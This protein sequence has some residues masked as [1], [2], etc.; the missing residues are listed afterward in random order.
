MDD[1]DCFSFQ[2]GEKC[3]HSLPVCGK[4]ESYM[5]E[6]VKNEKEHLTQCNNNHFESSHP[7]SG[8][9]D[10]KPFENALPASLPAL[11]STTVGRAHENWLSPI[12]KD[13]E[14]CKSPSIRGDESFQHYE[15]SRMETQCGYLSSMKKEI[16]PEDQIQL[17]D[18]AISSS[19]C[20]R[21]QQQD[22]LPSSIGTD[23]T[24]QGQ[25]VPS[26]SLTE[27]LSSHQYYPKPKDSA[28]LNLIS[29]PTLKES[30]GLS[31]HPTAI[32]HTRMGHHEE[33][34]YAIHHQSSASSTMQ[35]Q[36]QSNSK[37][38]GSSIT[39]VEVEEGEV[40]KRKTSCDEK[41]EEGHRS[42]MKRQKIAP[43]I[44]QGS[45][46]TTCHQALGLMKRIRAK[47]CQTSASLN[48]TLAISIIPNPKILQG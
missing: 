39:P 41:L 43:T 20:L 34:L 16:N 35:G 15:K 48:D 18:T 33:S 2:R 26:F 4:D 3:S 13:E 45:N 38:S 8:K 27:R 1:A 5:Y 24:D 25:V 32:S 7:V 17:S 11:T 10:V 37:P 31:C 29:D 12:Q 44:Q 40:G 14:H 19:D 21:Y 42:S 22:N 36:L 30:P 6:R 23:E 9:I 46:K 47:W 28:G